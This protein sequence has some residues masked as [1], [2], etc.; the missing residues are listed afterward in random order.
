MKVA[1]LNMFLSEKEQTFTKEVLNEVVKY[2]EHISVNE[3]KGSVVTTAIRN[4][5]NLLYP[6]IHTEKE[7]KMVLPLIFSEIEKDLK[8]KYA[9]LMDFEE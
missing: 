2:K 9:E 6:V 1:E 3:A 7:L 4:C 5:S 8:N